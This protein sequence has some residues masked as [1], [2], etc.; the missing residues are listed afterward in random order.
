MKSKW[1][2]CKFSIARDSLNRFSSTISSLT[3]HIFR[4]NAL[5]K[6]QRI[7]WIHRLARNQKWLKTILCLN[8]C[9][10]FYR[11]RFY[12]TSKALNIFNC[13]LRN[14]F[15]LGDI[16]LFANVCWTSLFSRLQKLTTIQQSP[17]R[18]SV[19]KSLLST[20]TRQTRWISAVLSKFY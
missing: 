6:P 9:V 17:L 16:N 5:A 2:K 11:H 13:H 20:N 19:T 7:S 15:S 4:I 3:M 12:S 14:G 10:Y 18:F 8:L 1:T